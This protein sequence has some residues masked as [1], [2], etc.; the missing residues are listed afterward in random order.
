MPSGPIE[1]TSG[2]PDRHHVEPLLR[3]TKGS[4]MPPGGSHCADGGAT[5]ASCERKRAEGNATTPS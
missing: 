2:V 4:S 1:L 3:L 5:L